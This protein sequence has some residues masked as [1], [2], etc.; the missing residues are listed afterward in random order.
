[1][2]TSTHSPLWVNEFWG[3]F[4][5]N[6]FD[7][8]WNL[9]ANLEVARI[10]YETKWL[11]VRVTFHRHMK[12][13]SPNTWAVY[14]PGNNV[15]VLSLRWIYVFMLYAS[16]FFWRRFHVSEWERQGSSTNPA[17]PESLRASTPFVNI[18]FIDPKY[19]LAPLWVLM[20]SL[21]LR[22]ILNRVAFPA[23]LRNREKNLSHFS[24]IM[25]CC[26]KKHQSRI[27]MFA[28]GPKPLPLVRRRAIVN[29]SNRAQ[30]AVAEWFIE[31]SFTDAY[32]VMEMS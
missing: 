4:W 9:K 16:S 28:S 17:D 12:N 1:M 5:R 32:W 29:K 13:D 15:L 19:L 31:G 2:T 22:S 8:L 24:W 26:W 3:I 27:F 18:N 10:Y 21:D 7:H 25:Q 23:L 6:C 20:I 11:R 14:A 30:N